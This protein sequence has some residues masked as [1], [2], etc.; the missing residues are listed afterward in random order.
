MTSKKLKKTK[1]Y[2]SQNY[3]LA[4]GYLFL[5]ILYIILIFVFDWFP[6]NA[7]MK[8]ILI[9]ISGFVAFFIERYIVKKITN[10]FKKK[11]KRER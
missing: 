7:F 11:K 5:W 1:E 3:G 10:L 6:N 4:K 8:G 9:V 2:S